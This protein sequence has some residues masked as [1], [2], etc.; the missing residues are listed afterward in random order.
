VRA[1]A[2]I[3]QVTRNAKWYRRSGIAMIAVAGILGLAG[4]GSGDA[5]EATV[6]VESVTTKA[7]LSLTGDDAE[8]KPEELT[9]TYDE[10]YQAGHAGGAKQSGKSA[11]WERGYAAGTAALE[12]ERQEA[13]K[14]AALRAEIIDGIKEAGTPSLGV[15]RDIFDNPDDHVGEIIRVDGV[16]LQY[17]DITG[18]N[19]FLG[20]TYVSGEESWDE[21]EVAEYEIPS[22]ATEL[23]LTISLASYQEDDEFSSIVMISGS[24]TYETVSDEVSTVPELL[25]L[26]IIRQQTI[27]ETSN[28]TTKSTPTSTLSTY[29]EE[30]EEFAEDEYIEEETYSNYSSALDPDFGT[31]KAA[32]AAGYGP[33]YEGSDPEYDWYTDRDGDGVVCE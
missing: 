10:G 33:Y 27:E 11:D 9:G 7:P 8:S 18:P 26:K 12:A 5:T 17:D 19:T 4:C 16:I 2:K 21:C 29:A 30:P 14:S 32:K 1:K 13:E 15:L 3:M 24:Y 23:G 6:V 22:D 28:P 31:C 25:L 20:C